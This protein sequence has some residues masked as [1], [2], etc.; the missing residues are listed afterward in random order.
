MFRK[1]LSVILIVFVTASCK[2]GKQ[3]LA[4]QISDGES[5]LFNDSAKTLNKEKA[6]QVFRMYIDYADKYKDDTSSAAY[7]FKAGDLA[8]GIMRPLESVALYE[9]LRK[10]YPSYR[11]AGAALFMEGFIYETAIQDKEKA[12]EKYSEFIKLY[13]DHALTP[14]AKASLDQLNDNLSDEDLIKK[15]EAMDTLR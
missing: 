11:K 2:S 3:E 13:P 6:S 9:R 4:E 12:K 1:Y 5:E 10:D 14:S 8:N 15:F 7:L